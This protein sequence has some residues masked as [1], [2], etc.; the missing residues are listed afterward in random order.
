MPSASSERNDLTTLRQLQAAISDV[1]ERI[2]A[3]ND[4]HLQAREAYWQERE[5]ETERRNKEHSALGERIRDLERKPPLVS[6]QELQ[7][8]R[9]F[10]E[11]WRAVKEPRME[12]WK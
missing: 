12:M 2:D 10:L 7:T 6:A 1:V 3:H 8:I 11:E 9:A 4:Q 5:R